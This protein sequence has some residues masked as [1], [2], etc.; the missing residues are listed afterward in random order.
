[1]P[2]VLAFT[3]C[4]ALPC[5]ALPRLARPR[6]APCPVLPTP[7]WVALALPSALWVVL[8]L[9]EGIRTAQD[10]EQKLNSFR[11]FIRSNGICNSCELLVTTRHG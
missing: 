3:A 2:F 6:P 9:V 7:A 8:W 1:M 4:A 11:D 10:H 5:H